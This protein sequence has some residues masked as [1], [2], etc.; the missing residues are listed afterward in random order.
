MKEQKVQLAKKVDLNEKT[1][2]IS[3]HGMQDFLKSGP[4]APRKLGHGLIDKRPH[5]KSFRSPGVK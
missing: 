4:K 1:E 2:I 3:K 5:F